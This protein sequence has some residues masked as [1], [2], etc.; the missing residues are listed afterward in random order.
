MGAGKG[1]PSMMFSELRA[2]DLSLVLPLTFLPGT[3]QLNVVQGWHLI[4]PVHSLDDSQVSQN[5]PLPALSGRMET[6]YIVDVWVLLCAH[7]FQIP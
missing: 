5:S 6:Y 2:S 1:I 7:S 3:I 4:V